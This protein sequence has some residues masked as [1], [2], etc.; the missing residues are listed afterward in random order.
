[1][2]TLRWAF[3]LSL[4]SVLFASTVMAQ[5][6]WSSGVQQPGSI[7]QMAF[8]SD[9]FNFASTEASGGTAAATASPSNAPP[10][11]PTKGTETKPA[12]EAPTESPQPQAA[13][14]E[15]GPVRLFQ[16]PWLD[17]R[18]LSLRGFLD[19]GY[20]ANPGYPL[21]KSNGPV[22]Y[23][24]RSNEIVL[25][26][27]W[28][29]AERVTKI[30][31]ECGG[32]DFG[33]RADVLYGADAR[34]A[35]TGPADIPPMSGTQ[36]DS[37]LNIG[38]RFY[39]LV[40][41]QFYGDLAF[42]KDSKLL[43]RGGHFLAPVGFEVVNA[44][45]NFFYSHTY[46]FLYGQPTTLTGGYATYKVKDKLSVNAGLDTGWN[47]F[48]AVNGK[49]NAFFGFNWTSPDEDGKINVIEEVFMGNTQTIPGDSFRYLFNTVVNVKLGDKWTYALEQ[50]FAHDSNQNGTGPASWTGWG[51]YLLY[52]INDCW[53]FGAR[54]EYFED[55]D[56]AVTPNAVAF[57]N[58]VGPGG[59]ATFLLPGAKYQDVTLG[60][61]WKPNKNV[62]VRTE[63]RWDWADQGAANNVKAYQDNSVNGQFLW[64]NDIIVRF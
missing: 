12:A 49:L 7:R 62:T 63:A 1:M 60:L 16:G 55:L 41:P 36:W 33:Y 8:Q 3:A 45:A 10:A 4:T 53:G 30:E 44:D 50:N 29:T 15:E 54:Y 51:N 59:I 19:A 26:Q 21:N 47:E 20:T 38:N 52:T 25:D 61:N 2:K 39:G 58:T 11:P 28:F 17:E 34:F 24:D 31:D 57:P 56:G 48:E 37:T 42:G 46:A 27:L 32:F 23:N 18:R 6:V 5:T 35:S 9:E 13:P 14:A 64:G 40:M 43:L 22:G